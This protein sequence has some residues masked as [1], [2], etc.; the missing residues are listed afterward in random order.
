MEG[1]GENKAGGSKKS[2]RGK[3]VDAINSNAFVCSLTRGLQGFRSLI[4]RPHGKAGSPGGRYK[5]EKGDARIKNEKSRGLCQGEGLGH[6]SFWF[7][8]KRLLF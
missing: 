1:E 3:R 2:R 5:M 6:K 8:D 4:T 7:R